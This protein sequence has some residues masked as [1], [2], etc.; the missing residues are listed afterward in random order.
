MVVN[1]GKCNDTVFKIKQ[2]PLEGDPPTSC[3]LA[4]SSIT[5]SVSLI[6]THM[7]STMCQERLTGLSV[8]SSVR[9]NQRSLEMDDVAVLLLKSRLAGSRF[10]YFADDD[11]SEKK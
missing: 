8:M 1:A 11:L 6:K 2:A 7:R 10:K 3:C 5:F 9:E 4:Y